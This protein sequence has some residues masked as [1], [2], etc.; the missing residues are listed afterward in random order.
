L[1]ALKGYIPAKMICCFAAL[2]NFCY[3][4]W[5]SVHDTNSLA[6]MN[7]KLILFCEYQTVFEDVGLLGWHMGMA[8][9]S[10]V[11]PG[12][13][14]MKPVPIRVRVQ[15]QT[16][17]VL[18]AGFEQ[19]HGYPQTRTVMLSFSFFFMNLPCFFLFSFFFGCDIVL[20]YF[21]CIVQDYIV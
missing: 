13:V 7:D 16:H 8:Q 6:A 14:P 10:E 12:P 21:F 3:L 9:V 4:A 17:T 5:R 19:H 18:P 2:L 20:L 15:V 1:P 11:Q